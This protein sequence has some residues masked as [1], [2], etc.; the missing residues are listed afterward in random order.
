MGAVPVSRL[1]D[2]Q[3]AIEAKVREQLVARKVR[4][5][6]LRGGLINAMKQLKIC[7]HVSSTGHFFVNR[8]VCFR[9]NLGH[10]TDFFLD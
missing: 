2:R 5:L 7:I 8:F 1:Q 6:I 10:P 4:G 3:R 9:E